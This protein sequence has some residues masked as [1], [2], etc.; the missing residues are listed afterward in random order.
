VD[1]CFLRWGSLDAKPIEGP[2]SF[3]ERL[4][5]AIAFLQRLGGPSLSLTPRRG[6]AAH[7]RSRHMALG[8]LPPAPG[9]LAFR[10]SSQK[11]AQ[12]PGIDNS[13][14]RRESRER[15]YY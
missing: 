15:P 14:M 11:F 9:Q 7:T 1:W 4:A 2:Q 10:E 5:V 6:A 3:G 12:A 8:T 13:R